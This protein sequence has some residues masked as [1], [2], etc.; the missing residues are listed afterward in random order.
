MLPFL[1]VAAVA[2]HR[3]PSHYAP[4]VTTRV[5]AVA[6]P[7]SHNSIHNRICMYNN[8]YQMLASL[9]AVDYAMLSAHTRRATWVVALL[10][11]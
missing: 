4:P 2:I 11:L 1:L 7:K 5:A 6:P 8:I 9:L 3:H 10:V